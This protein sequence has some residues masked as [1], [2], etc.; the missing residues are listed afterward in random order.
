MVPDQRSRLAGAT[1]ALGL[2]VLSVA[3]VAVLAHRQTEVTVDDAVAEFRADR[4]AGPSPSPSEVADVTARG[5]AATPSPTT[6]GGGTPHAPPP[7]SSSEVAAEPADGSDGTRPSPAPTTE[8]GPTEPTTTPSQRRATIPE[9]GVYTYATDGGESIDTLGGARHEYPDRT[10]ITVRHTD[11]GYTARWEPLRERW[12]EFDVC[13]G[14]H[15]RWMRT[16][17]LYHEFFGRGMRHAYTCG[18]DATLADG[19]SAS[20]Q[21]WTWEC[22]TDGGSMRTAIEVVGFETRDVGGEPVEAVHVRIRN[23]MEGDTRG[24][25]H[26]DVWYDRRSGLELH[27]TYDTDATVDTPTGPSRY[28]ERFRRTLTDLQPRR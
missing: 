1:L 17:T 28:V 24:T 11:C 23:T 21:R 18:E 22:H 15:R 2:L 27:G 8:P 26:A 20:D 5:D 9:E 10:T 14:D 13:R 4:G 6:P 19:S 12:E 25:R 3:G 16:I 7:P